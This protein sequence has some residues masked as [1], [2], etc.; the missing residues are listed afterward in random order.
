MTRRWPGHTSR[1]VTATTSRVP[2]IAIGAGT[3]AI[4]SAASA[5]IEIPSSTADARH[6]CRS[7]KTGIGTNLGHQ[8]GVR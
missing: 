7:S 3:A 2:K 8:H 4:I 5:K 6:E 1:S